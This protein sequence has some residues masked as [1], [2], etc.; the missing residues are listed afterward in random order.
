MTRTSSERV[1]EFITS[2]EFADLPEQAI[3]NAKRAILDCIGVTLAGHRIRASG[4]ILDYV[5]EW[6]GAGTSSVIGTDFR[7]PPEQAAFTNGY[8]AHVQDFDDR[9]HAST[10]T[11]PVVLALGEAAG[12]AGREILVAYVVGREVRQHIDEVFR[13]GRATTRENIGSGPG[14]RGWHETGVVGSLGAAAAAAKV[15]SLSRDQALMAIGIA[16]SLASGLIANFGTSTK[17]LHAANAAR[18]GVLAAILASKGHTSDREILTARRGLVE[19]VS[20]P[21][22]LD[23][24]PA[25]DGLESFLHIVEKGVRI[26]P[27][28]ACT[29][30]QRY[31]EAM[32]HLRQTW[33]LVPDEIQRIT[34]GRVAGQTAKRDFPRDE[35]ECKFSPAF[36]AVA[37][38]ISGEFSMHTCTNEYLDRDD[39]QAMLQR[40]AYADATEAFVRVET[41]SGQV[42]EASGQPIRD[43]TSDE[44]VLD[45]FHECA[46]PKVGSERAAAIVDLVS[47]LESLA[48]IHSLTSLVTGGVT[49]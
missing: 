49:A 3:A 6:T 26:K 42:H 5:G 44:E 46:D 28:P 38:L 23:I 18:N 40:T 32:L 31:I 1:A 14:W 36:V 43:L 7:L 29:G 17:A 41:R 34:V 22:T 11:L 9:G 20:Y 25:V 16:A 15:M 8:L 12:I 2:F 21:D 19:A 47:G 13:P 10:H 27:Y 48:S 35:L 39:V 45:K 4:A 30:V 37:S 33:G 24:S